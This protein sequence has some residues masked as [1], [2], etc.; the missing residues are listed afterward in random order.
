MGVKAS[1]LRK[2]ARGQ[3][4]QV[5]IYGVC[6]GNEE[7]TVLAHY[8]LAGLNGAGMKPP[9]M[10]GAYCCSSCHD[11]VDGRAGRLSEHL[12]YDQIRLYHAEGVFRTQALMVK[13][14]LIKIE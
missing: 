6:N 11:V 2:S 5:R 8:R 10:I 7:T 1:K 9:D 14:G 13:H 12:S 4:C 3:Q